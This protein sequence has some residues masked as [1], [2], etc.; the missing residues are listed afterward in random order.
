MLCGIYYIA[1]V[2]YM[3]LAENIN[4]SQYV[5]IISAYTVGRRESYAHTASTLQKAIE[6]IQKEGAE[7]CDDEYCFLVMRDVIDAKGESSFQCVGYYTIEGLYL[8]NS[9]PYSFGHQYN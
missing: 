4:D 5:F 3:N 7:W 2:L 8:S 9:S 1:E 6:W